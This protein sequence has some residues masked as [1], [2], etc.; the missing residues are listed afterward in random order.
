MTHLGG[1]VVLRELA[2]YKGQE[3]I[4]GVLDVVRRHRAAASVDCRRRA[5]GAISRA[6]D[7]A[8]E[9][10][11]R[12]AC[13]SQV[14]TSAVRPIPESWANMPLAAGRRV[15][16]RAAARAR[17]APRA[18][19]LRSDPEAHQGPAHHGALHDHAAAVAAGLPHAS[20]RSSGPRCPTSSASGSASTRRRRARSRPRCCGREDR[21]ARRRRD[22]R[23]LRA[24]SRSCTT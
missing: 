4:D 17:R 9:A 3:L 20:S 2:D 18:G 12:W 14:V 6:R 8:A 22:D 24:G 13:T 10:H 21:R 23:A 11:R 7:A 1:D 19:D 15:D 5:A 16:R